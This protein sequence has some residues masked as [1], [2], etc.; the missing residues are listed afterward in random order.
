MESQFKLKQSEINKLN[1]QMTQLKQENFAMRASSS[2]NQL[3]VNNLN[4]QL[5]LKDCERNE[6][7]ATMGQ[8]VK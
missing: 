7:E 8:E 1:K 2:N 3:K 4:E 6:L 5:K